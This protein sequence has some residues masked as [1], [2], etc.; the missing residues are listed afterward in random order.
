MAALKRQVSIDPHF[1]E[2]KYMFSP[3]ARFEPTTRG[4]L[5]A[6]KLAETLT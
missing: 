3:F 5:A 6:N 4:W 2:N 1:A